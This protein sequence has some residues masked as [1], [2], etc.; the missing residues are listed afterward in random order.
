MNS[1][2]WTLWNAITQMVG[3]T[4]RIVLCVNFSVPEK[5]GG[6]RMVYV[7]SCLLTWSVLLTY[8][9]TKQKD[10]WRLPCTSQEHYW[11]YGVAFF[12]IICYCLSSSFKKFAHWLLCIGRDCWS[13]YGVVFSFEA[14]AF[15]YLS[16]YFATL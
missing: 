4:I 10:L 7:W 11:K 6:L 5:L 12:H 2:L 13:A 9:V 1:R 14:F 15:A 16:K 3:L 8:I